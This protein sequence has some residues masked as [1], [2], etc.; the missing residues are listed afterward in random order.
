MKFSPCKWANHFKDS[1]A[2]KIN[3]PEHCLKYNHGKNLQIEIPV[4]GII[5]IISY[6]HG[7]FSL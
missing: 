6:V 2:C 1:N 4:A 5:Y 3:K 7:G